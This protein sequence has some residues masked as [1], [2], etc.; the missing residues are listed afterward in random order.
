MHSDCLARARDQLRRHDMAGALLCDPLNV[1]YVTTDQI[2]NKIWN[3]HSNFRYA[4]IPVE[5]DPVLWEFSPAVGLTRA[6]W[7]GDVRTA[8]LWQVFGA[9]PAA[10]LEARTFARDI[11]SELTARGI[12]HER[13]GIDR[14]EVDGYLA[15]HEA[16]VSIAD[17]QLAMA[18]AR[19]V[20]SPDEIKAMRHA[21]AVCDAAVAQ[22]RS[23]SQAGDHRA[24]TLGRLHR[25][26]H[27]VRARNTPRRVCWSPDRVRNHGCAKHRTG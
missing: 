27:R 2:S 22:L 5:S 12:Q 17:A 8:P 23:S 26:C 7:A 24:R 6:A 4:L 1:R 11:A 14:L 19:A 25:S 21:T 9:G 20:K 13:L 16:G 18:E 10:T 15:L 3:L